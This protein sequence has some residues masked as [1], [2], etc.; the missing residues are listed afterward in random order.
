MAAWA[1]MESTQQ[2]VEELRA[3]GDVVAPAGSQLKADFDGIMKE[4]AA[5]VAFVLNTVDAARFT[6]AILDR[7]RFISVDAVST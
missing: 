1:A 4:K 3:R 2:S 6:V 7:G 5:M